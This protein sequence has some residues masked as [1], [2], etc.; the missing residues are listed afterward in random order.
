MLVVQRAQW[1]FMTSHSFLNHREDTEQEAKDH[2][3]GDGSGVGYMDLGGRQIRRCAERRPTPDPCPETGVGI[4]H[5]IWR[6]QYR[7]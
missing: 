6:R 1:R 2:N 5:G 7:Y 4:G 3:G